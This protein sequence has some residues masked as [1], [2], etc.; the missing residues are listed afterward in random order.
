M[1]KYWF[2]SRSNLRWLR[3]CHLR[4]R[5]QRRGF[6]LI[7]FCP[8]SQKADSCMS[9]LQLIPSAG[10]MT[11]WLPQSTD[12]YANWSRTEQATSYN[13]TLCRNIQMDNQMDLNFISIYFYFQ[14]WWKQA[15]MATIKWYGQLMMQIF[16]AK[17]FLSVQKYLF[18][19]EILRSIKKFLKI[20]ENIISSSTKQKPSYIT[21]AVVSV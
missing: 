21:A 6:Y 12:N 4:W 17:I 13:N 9:G 19:K 7:S 20:K 1:I 11:P 2:N 15:F 8:C 16:T 18:D 3:S 14:E 5:L 10:C